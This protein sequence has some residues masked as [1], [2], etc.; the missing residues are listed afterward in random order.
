MRRLIGR[1]VAFGQVE[2]Q[3][4]VT[5]RLVFRGQR[6]AGLFQIGETGIRRLVA[7]TGQ[8][9]PGNFAPVFDEAVEGL[10]GVAAEPRCLCPCAHRGIGGRRKLA[11]VDH[12]RN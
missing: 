1:Q 9:Q 7:R 6:S 2:H 8:R 4:L 3:L 5:G 11:L 10:A 12:M